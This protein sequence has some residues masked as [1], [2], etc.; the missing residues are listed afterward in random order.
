MS[1]NFNHPAARGTFRSLQTETYTVDEYEKSIKSLIPQILQFFFDDCTFAMR[2]TYGADAIFDVVVPKA[3][4]PKQTSKKPKQISVFEAPSPMGMMMMFGGG[5][6]REKTQEEQTTW[7]FHAYLQLY[8][9][10]KEMYPDGPTSVFGKANEII[11]KYKGSLD[12]TK[13]E[14]EFNTS[15]NK[16]IPSRGQLNWEQGEFSRLGNSPAW[17]SFVGEDNSPIRSIGESEMRPGAFDMTVSFNTEAMAPAEPKIDY[18]YEKAL[19][20]VLDDCFFGGYEDAVMF[21]RECQP[22]VD[23]SKTLADFE[24]NIAFDAKIEV[25][26]I[27]QKVQQYLNENPVKIFVKGQ[28]HV[29]QKPDIK[30]QEA[31]DKDFWYIKYYTLEENEVV[32]FLKRPET[33]YITGDVTHVSVD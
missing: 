28:E 19:Q 24:G 10:L 22:L 18:D 8:K 13:E 32:I 6:A 20:Q 9:T 25:L 4:S 14:N 3:L 15:V 17:R 12:S 5:E 16:D 26:K 31:N 23:F 7:R 1:I 2:T 33:L 21:N 29:L 11:N 30:F 27:M